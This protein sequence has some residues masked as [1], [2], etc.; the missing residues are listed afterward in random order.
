VTQNEELIN[1]LELFTWTARELPIKFFGDA[2]LRTVSMPIEVEEFG[3]DQVKQIA[4]ELTNT[5]KKYREKTGLGR[6]LAANQIGYARRII[7]VLFD[8]EVE[9]MCNPGVVT[10]EGLG[11]YWESCISS[12]ASLVGEVHRPWTATFRYDTVDGVEQQLEADEKQTRIMLHEIDHIDGITCDEKYEPK[13]MKVVTGG[14]EEIFGY[15]F[16][17]LGS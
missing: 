4:V 11:S 5:L 7:A 14:K 2:V 8:D 6:G 9:V 3:S 15:A 16:K 12:G 13:T 17:K 1:S 10:S